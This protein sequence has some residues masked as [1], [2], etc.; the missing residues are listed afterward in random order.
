MSTQSQPA[1]FAYSAKPFATKR[2][3][4][5]THRRMAYIDEGEGPAIVFAHGNLTSSYLWRNIMPGVRS[6]GRL[7]A[8]DMIGMGDSDKLPHS[9]PESYGYFEQRDYLYALWDELDLGTE[10]ILVLHD[11][12]S[13]LGFDWA[14]QHRDRVQGIVYMESIVM[15]MS[16]SDFPAIYRDAFK[17][18]RGP[19]GEGAVLGRDFS[20]EKVVSDDSRRAL[21]K[22]E[23]AE[24]RR[25]FVNAGEDRRPLLSWPRQMPLDGEPADVAQV[26]AS[27]CGWLARSTVPKLYLQSNPG[28]LD[29]GR[30]RAFCSQWP[31][32][33]T[34]AI[35]G[36][37][38]V[39]EDSAPDITLALANFVRSLRG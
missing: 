36:T 37:H 20:V 33:K 7:V 32:Q 22:A 11:W 8:C 19:D 4:T 1:A 9:G 18:L 14:N 35:R 23:Q 2:Y 28:G 21:S 24:Y 15:P 16:W 5:I 34:V 26:I 30:M 17:S 31:N 12:G 39:Q 13:A 27:Y 10:V 6:H 25:P 29:S 3:A 38:F